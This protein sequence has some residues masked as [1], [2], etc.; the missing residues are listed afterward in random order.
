MKLQK[1]S[2][3]KVPILILSIFLL[4][5]C[6][7]IYTAKTTPSEGPTI[8]QAVKEDY[9][10]PKARIAVTRFV[11]KSAKGPSSGQIGDGMAEMLAN[12]LFATNRYIVL[13]RQSLGDVTG[14]QDFGASGRV[15]PETAARIGE[16]EG[17]D[18][19]VEGTITEFDPGT[20]SSTPNVQTNLPGRSQAT[21]GTTVGL[22]ATI[23]TSH[24]ALIVKM[25]DSKTGRRLASEQVEAKAT[26]L[27]VESNVAKGPLL[28]GGL[29][30]FAN[31]SMEKAI[32]I[33]INKSVK[34]I[35]AKTPANY[36]RVGE[37]PQAP[38]ASQ[39]S[40]SQAR[41]PVAS[42][43]FPVRFAQVT[44]SVENLR[45][46]PGGKIIGKA[47]QGT[48]LQVFE[49]KGKWLHVRLK[50][51]TEAWIWKASTSPAP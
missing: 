16:I 40:P 36:Y 14:E 5:G 33:S 19:L 49:E 29:S 17:A 18:I 48:P 27:G 42:Q 25:I 12:A 6:T 43:P 10:G 47:T 15:R 22:Q 2:I 1:Y 28:S 26:D 50:D 32:R 39:P 21:A 20:S 41:A 45:D 24:L 13:E 51:G 11:D 3:P 44:K 34:A 9:N 30:A 46:G 35:V 7:G 4:F 8:D 37:T 23:K 38:V 31:T